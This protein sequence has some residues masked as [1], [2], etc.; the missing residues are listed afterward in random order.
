MQELCF[1]EETTRHVVGEQ[2]RKGKGRPKGELSP[3]GTSWSGVRI[4]LGDQGNTAGDEQ[5]LV[6]SKNRADGRQAR[7]GLCYRDG[8]RVGFESKEGSEG[9]AREGGALYL[10][11]SK[12]PQKLKGIK[13]NK[14][15]SGRGKN[16]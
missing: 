12:W 13:S 6:Y 14:R 8:C 7:K 10:S 3:S 4:V 15:V 11:N 9:I 2:V 1:V 16:F 5:S